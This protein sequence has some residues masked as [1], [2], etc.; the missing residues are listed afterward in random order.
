M[1]RLTTQSRGAPPG[2][3]GNARRHR[4]LWRGFTLV[5]LLVV[6]AIIGILVA[7][8]LPAVN[9][10]RESARR[11]Q[12][13]NNLKQIALALQ[14]FESNNGQFPPGTMAKQRF[15]YSHDAT[16]GGYEWPYFLH[17]LLPHLEQQNY[18]EAIRGP[19]FD[20][21]NPWHDPAAWPANVNNIDWS[22]IRCPSDTRASAM[23]RMVKAD[24]TVTPLALPSSNYLGIF[25]G[26]NDGEN[27]TGPTATKAALFRYHK[28]VAAAD[29]KDGLS[30]TM[31]VAEYLTGTD[32]IDIRGLFL[33]NRAGCQ[34]LYV[35]LGPNST[36]PDNLL[37]WHDSFCPTNMS[38]NRPELNLPCT[39]GDT[40]QNYASPR[41]RHGGGVH[42]A[43]L[44]G[45]V[46]FLND[47]I[48]TE[49]WQPLG[50]I[51][52]GAPPGQF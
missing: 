39:P 14:A 36:A 23:K 4:L 43:F 28:G 47:A 7:M 48:A 13:A 20:I 32:E 15:S 52:D 49:V 51:A 26:L 19:K 6:I 31:A 9:S 3:R 46:H 1:E 29:I 25:G 33:T 42:A 41:S 5:E 27:Y 40:D 37:S 10:A 8:L 50:W 35:T 45:S 17:Y 24:G 21:Q 18:Y 38:R 30:N 2:I 16:T 12:C 11:I 34:F 22:F 44:D